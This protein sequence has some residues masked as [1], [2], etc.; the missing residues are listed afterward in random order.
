LP[1]F[2]ELQ[3]LDWITVPVS[4]DNEAGHHLLIE[5]IVN[6]LP[7]LIRVCAEVPQRFQHDQELIVQER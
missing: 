1:L 2:E 7:V 3:H 4:A 6:D 5:G